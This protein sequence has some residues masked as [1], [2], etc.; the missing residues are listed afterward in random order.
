MPS[1]PISPRTSYPAVVDI[2]EARS[3]LLFHA[4]R[5]HYVDSSDEGSGADSPQRPMVPTTAIQ[6]VESISEIEKMF[7]FDLE[8][9]GLFGT[10]RQRQKRHEKI[11]SGKEKNDKTPDPT[12]KKKN[13]HTRAVI[14]NALD[15]RSMGYKVVK[16]IEKDKL[17]ASS[18]GDRY[19]P[20]LLFCSLFSDQLS[21]C[22][23]LWINYLIVPIDRL[24]RRL[25][26]KLLRVTKSYN[27]LMHV[28]DVIETDTT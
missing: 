12:E 14:H 9:L 23:N 3:P 6:Y 10:A 7:R 2:D 24:W 18:G 25:C 5:P 1:P 20:K 21:D 4:V 27:G 26:H 19:V 15:L 11:D 13:S 16:I 22:P 28:T 17:P 8:T